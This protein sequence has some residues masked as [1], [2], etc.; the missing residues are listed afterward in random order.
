M[1]EE[2]LRYCTSGEL[3]RFPQASHWLQHEQ[4]EDVSRQMIQFFQGN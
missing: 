1:A 2:S 3:V 4:P